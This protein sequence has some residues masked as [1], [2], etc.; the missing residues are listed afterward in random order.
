MA[1]IDTDPILRAAAGPAMSDPLLPLLWMNH[2]ACRGKTHLF[3]PPRAERP[4]ARVRR[5]AQ[6]RQ[7]C[8]TCPAME[9]C[10]SWARDNREYGF[11]G[12]ES[13]EERHLAGFTVAA[14]IGI[15]AR[16][17]TGSAIHS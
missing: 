10:R 5:E 1:V 9:T 6:A 17:A 14:P 15:R 8:L 16:Q 12:G 13:E 3:F 4:Q 11:W 7:V 2:A